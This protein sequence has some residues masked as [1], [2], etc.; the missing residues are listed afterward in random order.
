[1]IRPQTRLK[2]PVDTVLFVVT[3]IL[4]VIGL[5]MVFD[6]SFPKALDNRLIGSDPYYFVKRQALGAMVGV[7]GLFA[8]MQYGYWNLR[9]HAVLFMIVGMGLLL[10]VYIPHLGVQQNNAVR[11]LKL[12]P[13]VFQASELA[14]LALIIYTAGFLSRPH[15]NPRELGERGLAPLLLV[16]TLFV[17][18]IEREP[19]LGTAAVL[20]LAFV[21]QLFL[22]G[23][24]KRHIALIL[25]VC[26]LAVMMMGF[27]F[28]HRAG[29]ITTFLHPE[30]DLQGSGYQL[31]H[32][33]MGIGSG[34]LT[35]VGLGKGREKYFLP[36]GNSDFIFA[37]YAEELGLAGSLLL[38][39]LQCIVSWR[40]FAIA[41]QTKDQFGSLLASGIAALISWQAL[42]NIGTAT[43]SIPATGVPLP[44]ISNG[45]TS[46][47][48][49]MVCIGILL[50]IAQHPIP[51]A[52]S[53]P[54]KK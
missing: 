6:S 27:G 52:L 29:R 13:V 4:V 43:G 42:I 11:W 24:R 21:T 50:S 16:A 20:Y 47:I 44:F 34:G 36:Q 8:A 1:M 9:R 48:Q 26:G 38:L 23:A 5:W 40:G 49:L 37:T 17:V 3:L 19:D 2:L 30:K 12:G 31:Y 7:A 51:P 39:G 45:A 54:S 18:L 35:G 25:T 28:G 46:L 32:S 10:A 33:T 22:A 53:M 41:Q 14:K 15:C